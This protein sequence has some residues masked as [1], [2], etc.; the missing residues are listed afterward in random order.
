MEESKEDRMQKTRLLLNMYRFLAAEH[1]KPAAV[2]PQPTANHVHR[3]AFSGGVLSVHQQPLLTAAAEKSN[4]RSCFW[5]SKAQAI[6]RNV[7]LKTDVEPVVVPADAGGVFPVELVSCD[8]IDKDDLNYFFES[9]DP[10][11]L[12]STGPVY[13]REDK[14]RLVSDKVFV[15]KLHDFRE[16]NSFSSNRWVEKGE[17]SLLHLKLNVA[18]DSL[19]T[20]TISEGT[21]VQL[22]NAEQTENPS[23]LEAKLPE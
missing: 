14:W 16:H 11:G 15:Q 20:I 17:L 23:Q 19:P 2:P 5:I 12:G 4:F 18:P 3:A 6:K 10:K 7:Q 1:P 9:C 13:F 8:C 22:Y 21:W